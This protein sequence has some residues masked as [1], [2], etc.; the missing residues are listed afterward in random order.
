MPAPLVLVV[1]DEA[2]LRQVTAEA[3]ED[4]GYRV[5]QADDGATALAL[6]RAERPSALVLDLMMP[7]LDGWGLI[8]ALREAVEGDL[9]VVA[10]S[11]ALDPA[12]AARLKQLGVR[13]CLAKP[14]DLAELLDCVASLLRAP[15]GAGCP[16]ASG[17]SVQ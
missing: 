15:A 9:P 1:D 17:R 12:S 16:E 2:P 10:V 11:A 6:L 14:Y 8:E 13:Y 3:L 7:V 5:V 4:E